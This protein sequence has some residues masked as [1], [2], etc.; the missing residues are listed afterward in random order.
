M[1]LDLE[2][3]GERETGEAAPSLS[4]YIRKV[5]GRVRREN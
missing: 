1:G 4:D 3:R 5:K 2:G